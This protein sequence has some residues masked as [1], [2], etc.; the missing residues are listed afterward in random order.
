MCG[1]KTQGRL[2]TQHSRFIALSTS[3]PSP[4]FTHLTQQ[5]RGLE[6]RL[7]SI[8]CHLNAPKGFAPYQEA[9]RMTRK[10]PTAYLLVA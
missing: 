4:E 7:D 5:P 2:L 9:I 1:R 3:A 10:S 6:G 8:S